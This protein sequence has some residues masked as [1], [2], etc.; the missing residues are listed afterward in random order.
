MGSVAKAMLA[1]VVGAGVIGACA[2][3]KR[4]TARS[5]APTVVTAP[6]PPATVLPTQEEQDQADK[7]QQQGKNPRFGEAAVYADGKAIGVIRITELPPT[8]KKHVID[9]GEGY[10]RNKYTFLEYARAVGID[11]K[12]LKAMHLY[13]GQRVVVVDHAELERIGEKIT[14]SFTQGDRGKPRV[15]WPA[16][17]L[18]VNTTIEMVSNVIFYLDKAPPVLKDGELVY[19]DGK[20]IED[21]KVPYAPEEQG[22]GTRIYVDGSLVGVVKRKKLDSSV[23]AKDSTDKFSLIAY[24]ARLDPKA[25]DAKTIDL[26]AGDDVI[27][28]V[29][30]DA[31]FVVPAKNRGQAVVDVPAA[32]GESE[33]TARISAVQI[34]VRSAPPAR[35]VTKISDA[36]EAR[37]ASGDH[38]GRSGDDDL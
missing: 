35:T 6:K 34:F 10:T 5:A 26:I 13:G 8:L 29:E 9:L 36:P 20:P 4:T 22:S 31:T 18:N 11:T 32:N 1:L 3:S 15:H 7:Q 38:K 19:P 16:M 25:K 30:K 24:A 27:G 17:K 33:Q 14:F 21:G 28:R 2:Q 12:R 23:A 37:L